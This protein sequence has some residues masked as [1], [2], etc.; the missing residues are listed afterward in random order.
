MPTRSI[1]SHGVRGPT[2][3]LP[4]L[5]VVVCQARIFV[6]RATGA[7]MQSGACGSYQPFGS[8][9]AR[10]VAMASSA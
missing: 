1:S 7:R 8:R 6:L 3:L 9:R 4:G 2:V 5:G 10:G